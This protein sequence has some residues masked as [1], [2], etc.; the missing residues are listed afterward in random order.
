MEDDLFSYQI[1]NKI[2]RH[3]GMIKALICFLF[4]HKPFIT[5]QW[6]WYERHCI[7]CGKLLATE[8]D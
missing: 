7:R 4:Q 1:Y 8:E 2:K 3:R 5:C 6:G